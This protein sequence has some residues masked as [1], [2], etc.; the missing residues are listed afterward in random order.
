MP[1]IDTPP[2]KK[3][4]PRRKSP[5]APLVLEGYQR[6]DPSR[7]RQER[8]MQWAYP[9]ASGVKGTPAAAMKGD[10][11]RAWAASTPGSAPGIV[12]TPAYAL[13]H[14]SVG[15]GAPPVLPVAPTTIK[16]LWDVKWQKATYDVPGGNKPSWWVNLIPKDLKDAE[17]PDVQYLMMLNT[18]LPYLSPEDQRNAASQ[19]YTTAADAFSY[20]KPKRIPIT[21]PLS[22]EEA[23]QSAT[24][25]PAIDLPYFESQARSQQAI[26]A[27]SNLR[28]STVKGNRWKLGPGYTWLQQILGTFGGAGFG[29]GPGQQRMTKSQQSSLLGALD[30]LLA[31]GQSPEIGPISAIGR[32]L[33]TPF[34]S[35]R[36]LRKNQAGTSINPYLFA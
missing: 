34:F 4:V 6:G 19:L 20:Y 10:L 17:R 2:R 31:Q 9:S 24:N 35:Q 36:N 7:S 33:A 3:P 18:M 12:G 22:P 1:G 16:P 27:L 25:A 30:P 11:L 29:A 32:M 21:V 28:E 13:S 8:L 26:Q 23:A 15:G 14:P 5:L